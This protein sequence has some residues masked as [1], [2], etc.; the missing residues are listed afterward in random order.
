[1][2]PWDDSLNS[3]YLLNKYKNKR[4]PI[5][6]ILLDQSIVVGIGN[7]YADEILFKSRIN[8]L[9][10][11]NE[12]NKKECDDIIKYT[13]EILSDA[14]KLGGT[15]IKSYESSRGVHGKFQNHLLIHNHE[16]DKC[17]NCKK[18]IKK[19]KV[20]GRSTYYCPNCQK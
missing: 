10:R 5:K 15:T 9:K 6:T 13:K 14:I 3:N 18:I 20:N 16:N 1:M 8:P 12:L 2:E 19:I 17:V 7:I 11:G 4:I